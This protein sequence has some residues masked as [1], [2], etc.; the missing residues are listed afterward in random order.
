MLNTALTAYQAQTVNARV[1]ELPGMP[2]VD[3]IARQETARTL[4]VLI[5]TDTSTST[6]TPSTST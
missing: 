4:K 2:N 5:I 3:M 6:V 1:G